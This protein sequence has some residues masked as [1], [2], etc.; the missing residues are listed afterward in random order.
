VLKGVGSFPLHYF[1]E[2]FPRSDHLVRLNAAPALEPFLPTSPNH[3]GMAVIR[4]KEFWGDRGAENDVLSINGTD[5]VNPTTAPSGMVGAASVVFFVFD[6][7]SDDVSN[8]TLIPT[9]F[10]ALPFLTGA[11]LSIRVTGAPLPVVTVPRGD[12][13][14]ARTINVRCIPGNTGRTVVQLHDFE[15]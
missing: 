6:V 8:L 4:Y 14:A 7:G 13:S 11:D 10:G 2:Q 5:V 9:P 15:Q 12:E 3:C 1:Y